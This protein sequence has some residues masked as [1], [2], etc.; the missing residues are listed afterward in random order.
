MSKYT[1]D[2]QGLP[3]PQP[4]LKCKQFLENNQALELEIIVDNQ[5]ARENVGRFLH[6]VGYNVSSI[7]EN[8]GLIRIQSLSAE[9][10]GLDQQLSKESGQETAP[11]DDR[12]KSI[13]DRQLVFISSQYLGQ[14]SDELGSKLM[15]NFI[16]TLPEM[17]SSLW[18]LILVNSAVKLSVQGSPVLAD[19]N[20]L[21]NSG[22]NI[23]VCGTCLD[24]FDLLDKKQVGQTTNMLDVVTGLQLADKVIKI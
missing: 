15:Q 1:L 18:K 22:V 7:K 11:A 6:S 24:Y 5:A 4:V 9:Q 23:L 2:C 14:G 20:K 19:L 8:D 16:A 3:C 10:T 21:E 17:G 12:C 13:A